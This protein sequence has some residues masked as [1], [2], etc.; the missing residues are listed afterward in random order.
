MSVLYMKDPG[1]REKGL[2]QEKYSRC[3]GFESRFGCNP[4]RISTASVFLFLFT[5]Y[6]MG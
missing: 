2:G 1:F 3:I 5:L 6:Q 4:G